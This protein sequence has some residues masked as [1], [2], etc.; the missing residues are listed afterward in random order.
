MRASWS[1]RRHIRHPARG[2]VLGDLH[3]DD[4]RLETSPVTRLHASGVDG[5]TNLG[6]LGSARERVRWAQ[7]ASKLAEPSCSMLTGALQE[8]SCHEGSPCA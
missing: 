8:S 6:P 5:R 4:L 1:S 2:N 7:C 3:R